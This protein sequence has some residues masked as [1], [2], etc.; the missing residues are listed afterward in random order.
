MPARPRLHPSSAGD[1]AADEAERALTGAADLGL[2]QEPDWIDSF[3][4]LVFEQDFDSARE[5]L[6]KAIAYGVNYSLAT[7]YAKVLEEFLE[8]RAEMERP[9]AELAGSSTARRFGACIVREADDER[10]RGLMVPALASWGDILWR[11]RPLAYIQSPCSRKCVQVCVACCRPVGSLASQLAHMGLP[12]APAGAEELLCQA[13]PSDDT[14]PSSAPSLIPCLGEGCAEVFC[15]EACRDWALMPEATS[16]HAL[17]CFGRLP[18]ASRVALERLERLAEESDTEHLLLLA[19]SVAVMVLARQRGQPLEEVL[20]RYVGQFVSEPWD[21]LAAEGRGASAEDTPESRRGLLARATALI[22]ELF[23]FVEP[24]LAAPLLAPELLSGLLGSY[25]LVNMCISLLHPLNAEGNRVGELLKGTGILP[26]L[27][28]F[29]GQAEQD[30]DSEAEEEGGEEEARGEGAE[31]AEEAGTTEEEAL[32]AAERG[33]LFSYVVGSAHC[34]ALAYTNHACLPN[35]NI[36]FA[37]SEDA[38]DWGPGL[39][40]HGTA[41]RPLMP[42]DEVLMTYVPSVVGRPLEVRQR[43]MKRFGFA[44]RCRSCLTDFMLEAEDVPPHVVRE[45]VAGVAASLAAAAHHAAVAP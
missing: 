8:R 17:L 42:G 21:A 39:W 23:A 1:A 9:P 38:G 20:Q 13:R 29:Q 27:A 41:R 40:V 31:G 45:T 44:C 12:A 14:A 11:E 43:R 28:D 18:A 4:R 5:V 19:H 2:P 10:G 15:G 3:M 34:E 33:T 35:C 7:Q 37:T 32:E 26:L 25:E 16:S 30:S 6:R 22:H 36:D 24:A